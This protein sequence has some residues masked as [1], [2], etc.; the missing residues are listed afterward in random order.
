MQVDDWD[1]YCI[2][3]VTQDVVQTLSQVEA[4][5]EEVKAGSKRQAKGK[6]PKWGPIFAERRSTRVKHD[7]RTSLEKA[8][9]NKKKD[10]VDMNYNKG[11]K[12]SSKPLNDKHLLHVTKTVGVDLGS[13]VDV[14]E[15]NLEACRQFD[16]HRVDKKAIISQGDN[17]SE[18]VGSV[19]GGR[20]MMRGLMVIMIRVNPRM[21]LRRVNLNGASTL[22][23]VL[24]NECHFLEQ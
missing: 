22:G 17:A 14:I 1:G 5:L 9:D 24:R 19:L 20:G 4:G 15:Y 2:P 23:K 11:K 10:E 13:E 18:I 6:K 21:R 8:K 7:G 12:K 16:D 3:S